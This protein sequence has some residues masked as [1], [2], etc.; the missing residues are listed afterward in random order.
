MCTAGL[1]LLASWGEPWLLRAGWAQIKMQ[2]ENFCKQHQSL[3]FCGGWDTQN[4]SQEPTGNSWFVFFFLKKE[5][6]SF[7]FV[8]IKKTFTGNMKSNMKSIIQM[9]REL[10][11]TVMQYDK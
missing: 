4:S 2:E 10:V 11:S 5:T 1:V 6:K 9:K 3:Y 8:I 7:I